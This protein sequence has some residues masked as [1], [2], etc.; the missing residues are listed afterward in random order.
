MATLLN[1]TFTTAVGATAGA[2]F[3]FQ[4]GMP[5]S[6]AVQGNFTYGS[7]GTSVDAYLQTSLDGG[8]TWQDIANFHFTT[9]SLRKLI[10]LSSTTP[11]T[12]QVASSDGAL[13]ANTAQDGLLGGLLRVKYAST[14]TYAGGTTLKIDVASASR[15]VAV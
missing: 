7:A 10:N 13:S 12:T 3:Q 14:G 2:S 9:S 15:I 8:T 6:L 1:V 11:V 4:S 5:R